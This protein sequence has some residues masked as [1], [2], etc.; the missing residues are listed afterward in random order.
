MRGLSLLPGT[1]YYFSAR[2]QNRAGSW[3]GWVGSDAFQ[4][5]PASASPYGIEISVPLPGE[6]VSGTLQVLGIAWIR[7]GWTRNHSVQFRIDDQPWRFLTPRGSN[8][9]RNWSVDWDTRLLFDGP[10]HV[11]ARLVSG[12]INST[13]MASADAPVTVNNSVGPPPLEAVFSPPPGTPVTLDENG[14]YE[15][16]VDTAARNLSITWHVDGQP[17]TG[18]T[19][20]KF[21]F[22]PTYLMAGRH[23]VTVYVTAGARTLECTWNVT[24]V[25]VDRPPVAGIFNPPPGTR[26]K[27]GENITFNAATSSDPDQDDTL[28][29]V[30]DLGDGTQ[31]EGLEVTH[32]Y[33]TAGTYRIMLKVL[34]G[35]LQSFAEVNLTVSNPTRI[36]QAEPSSGAPYFLMVLVVAVAAVSAAGFI[37]MR[38]RGAGEAAA[39]RSKSQVMYRL[40]APSLVDDEEE[41]P[42]LR[43]T[44]AEQWKR[45][46][47]ESA[48]SSALA[49]YPPYQPPASR[50]LPLTGPAAPRG[51]HATFT[52]PSQARPA[53]T[54]GPQERPQHSPKVQPAG[55]TSFEDIPEV[56]VIPEEEA[57]P[58]APAEIIPVA[59][60]QSYRPAHQARAPAAPRPSTGPQP[61]PR[62]Q[63]PPRQADSFDELM[64]LLE[65][66]R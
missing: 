60:A 36:I 11:W 22:H 61:Q 19:Y 33:K 5:W 54:S 14:R 51:A 24:V 52:P 43:E 21:V 10:H 25:N 48:R 4:Y 39:K 42:R 38:R 7:D 49:A 28:R 56:E 1:N 40:P 6:E 47:S 45:L 9:T 32:A 8:Q 2:A 23:N 37:Y 55:D 30:W 65:K 44:S 57:I 62:P 50:A 41:S 29:Y 17:R 66:N 34:D 18:E 13:E 20:A 63:Q 3:S 59:P 26:W 12:L 15:F 64:A 58:E 53:F 35:T 31:S 46:E 27:T 16:S